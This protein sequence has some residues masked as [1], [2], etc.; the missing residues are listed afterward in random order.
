M[1][2]GC[3][4]RFIKILLRQLVSQLYFLQLQLEQLDLRV[5]ILQ[6]LLHSAYDLIALGMCS[7]LPTCVAARHRGVI[8]YLWVVRVGLRVFFI[9]GLRLISEIEACREE[10]LTQLMPTIHI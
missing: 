2:I 7:R 5:C 6:L 8:Q 1:L 3:R 9:I 10:I 4:H